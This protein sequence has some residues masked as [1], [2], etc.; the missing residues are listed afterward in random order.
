MH[1]LKYKDREL[2]LIV[3][4]KVI[5]AVCAK[6]NLK[7]SQFEKAID[8]P[9]DSEKVFIEALRRGHQLENIPYNIDDAEIEEILSSCYGTFLRCFTEDVLKMFAVQD[10]KKK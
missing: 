2:P 6:L 8:N 3:D 1:Y 5:K 7:L 4:F 10:D 9:E